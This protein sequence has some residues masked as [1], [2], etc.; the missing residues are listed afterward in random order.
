M[1]RLSGLA[2]D[3][4]GALNRVNTESLFGPVKNA[5]QPNGATQ[6]EG[7]ALAPIKEQRHREF[8]YGHS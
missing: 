7:A 2:A 8:I 4:R 1:D 6:D 3:C 5:N